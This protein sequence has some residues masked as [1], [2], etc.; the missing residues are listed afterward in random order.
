MSAAAGVLEW[1]VI[2]MRR[3]LAAVA[4]AGAICVAVDCLY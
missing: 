3:A 1:D 2:S 4:T